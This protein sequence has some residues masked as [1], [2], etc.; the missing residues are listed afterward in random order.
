V[1]R[2]REQVEADPRKPRLIQ[3]VRG[4]GYR[5][6]APAS[7]TPSDLYALTRELRNSFATLADD[8]EDLGTGGDVEQLLAQ[9]DRLENMIGD[10]VDAVHRRE[11]SGS[12]GN[13]D[14]RAS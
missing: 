3:T 4:I 1:K 5:L 7:R 14:R 11:Q 12:E 13:E 2:L 9:L 8:L 6:D 10:V